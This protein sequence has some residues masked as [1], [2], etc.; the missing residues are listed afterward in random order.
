MKTY[1]ADFLS[2]LCQFQ[3]GT[4]TH[5]FEHALGV[6]ENTV[7]SI[8]SKSTM[9][10]VIACLKTHLRERKDLKMKLVKIFKVLIETLPLPVVDENNKK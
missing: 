1:A 3:D 7:K 6:I 10:M 5:I 9:L 4:L 2:S 8:Y